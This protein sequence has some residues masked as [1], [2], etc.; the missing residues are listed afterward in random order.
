MVATHHLQLM[1][2]SCHE[3]LDHLC[4][5]PVKHADGSLRQRA[6]RRQA[7]D[8]WPTQLHGLKLQRVRHLQAAGGTPHSRQA[9]K[10]GFKVARKAGAAQL[11]AHPCQFAATCAKS[12]DTKSIPV[13]GGAADTCYNCWHGMQRRS[14]SQPLHGAHLA[15]LLAGVLCQFCLRDLAVQPPQWPGV[16]VVST[17]KLHRQGADRHTAT[18]VAAL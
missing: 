12:G 10:C 13:V 14:G 15:E 11:A 5:G 1:A 8:R 4:L 6:A 7:H 2:P 17:Q 16:Q 9:A 3:S 18:A